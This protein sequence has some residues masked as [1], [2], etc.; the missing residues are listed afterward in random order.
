MKK[1][2][3][4]TLIALLIIALIPTIYQKPLEAIELRISHMAPAGSIYDRQITAWA[5]KIEEESKGKLT[6]RIFPGGTLIGPFV[7]YEG[8]EKGVADIGAS[9]R[10]SRAGAELTGMLSMFLAG[11]PDAKTA[12]RIVAEVWKKFPELSKEWESVKILWTHASGPAVVATT[13]PVRKMADLKGLSLRS[14]VPEASDALRELGGT[15]VSMTSADMVIGIQK[16]TVHGG[17]VFKEAIESFK[18]PVK[19]ITEFGMYC[20]SNWF[21]VMN[22][23]SWKKLSP[24]L[25]KIIDSSLE[26]GRS[27][28]IKAFDEADASAVA[29]AKSQGMEI[30]KLPPDEEAAWFAKVEASYKKHAAALDAKGYPATKVFEFIKTIRK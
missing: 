18:L 27:E 16:G 11:M 28:S 8:I 5:K 17:L 4:I 24:D 14:P 20:S 25:Q 26:W 22:W 2:L 13:K 15:P 12:S 9:Y 6:F 29:Y 21:M 19:F 1:N 30:I 7:T 23:D 3:I 10:Y